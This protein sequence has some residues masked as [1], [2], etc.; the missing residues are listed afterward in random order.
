MRFEGMLL[1]EIESRAVIAEV[2]AW[3]R[4]TGTNYNKLVT[5][6]G[7]NVSTRSSVMHRNRRLTTMTADRLRATMR[8]HK[9]GISKGEHRERTTQAEIA[10]YER[11]SRKA[12]REFP[13]ADLPR[14]DRTPC[15]RCGVRADIGCEHSHRDF[16]RAA[17]L[18][19][20]RRHG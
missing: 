1:T 19:Y 12:R 5:A 7:V 8:K 3:C 11:Q 14:V 13:Q 6:A 17:P 15:S 16:E 20:A 2:N 4:R 10:A 9:H 18:G